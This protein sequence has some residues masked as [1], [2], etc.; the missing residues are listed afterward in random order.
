M[1]GVDVFA[2]RAKAKKMLLPS[3][4]APENRKF[5]MQPQLADMAG[6]L[7]WHHMLT[8]SA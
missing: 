1:E 7:N 8:S 6:Q 2:L 4:P 5:D 3:L